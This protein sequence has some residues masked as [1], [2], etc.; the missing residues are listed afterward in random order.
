MSFDKASYLAVTFLIERATVST[1]AVVALGFERMSFIEWLRVPP[2]SMRVMPSNPSK[3]SNPR[4]QARATVH[5]PSP[6]D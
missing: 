3:S 2:L 1:A 5:H 6:D 4:L